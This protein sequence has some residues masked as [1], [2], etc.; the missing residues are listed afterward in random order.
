[1]IVFGNERFSLFKMKNL[2]VSLY[3][4]GLLFVIINWICPEFLLEGCWV[5]CAFFILLFFLV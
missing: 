5:G 1:M 2:F 4:L 3:V